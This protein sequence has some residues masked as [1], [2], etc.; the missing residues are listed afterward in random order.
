[1]SLVKIAKRKDVNF[2]Y[3]E[4]GYSEVSVLENACDQAKFTRCSLQQGCSVKPKLYTTKE[5]TQVFL[6][7]GGSGYIVT[8]RKGFNIE[9]EFAVFV[10]D[11][12]TEEFEIVCSTD[13]KK[14]LEY[15]HVVTELN[16]YDKHCLYASKMRLP[17]FRRLQDG[18]EYYEAFKEEGITSRMLLEH[19]NLGRVSCGAVTGKGPTVVG[20]HIHNEI[21]QW[22]IMLPGSKMT[23]TAGEESTL[24]ESGD[25]SF[26]PTGFFHGSEAAEGDTI[27]YIWFEMVKEMYP[28]E[29]E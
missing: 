23:Y 10:P 19:R 18:W 4:N 1:M 11:Y 28:G 12:D 9:N 17:R 21:L 15:I 24:L 14:P 7:M 22:Y 20:Q 2:D 29:I 3:N 27:D 16:D 6:F 25:I 13:S 8:P 5:H 26:T